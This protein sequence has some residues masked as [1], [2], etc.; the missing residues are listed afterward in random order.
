MNRIGRMAGR[1]AGVAVLAALWTTQAT[2]NTAGV[3]QFVAGD[4]RVALAGGSERPAAKGA[5]ISVGDTVTTARASMAQIK[6]GD[7]AIIVVQPE[8]RLTVAEFRY[9]GKEDG[10]EKVQFRLEQGGFRSVT[11]AIGHTNKGSYV[12]ETPIA[13]IGVRGTDHESYYFPTPSSIDGEP[14]QAG[15]YNK[16][17]VGLTYIRTGSGEVVIQP[18]QVGYAASAQDTPHLLGAMPE[19]FNRGF[20]PRSVQRGGRPG[21]E[22]SPVAA[23]QGGSSGNSAGRGTETLSGTSG[24]LA[25]YTAPQGSRGVNFG[26]TAVN[27][28]ISPNG[29]TLANAGGN[30]TWGVNWGT[31]QGGPTTVNGR[32]TS[33]STNFIASTNLTTAAQLAA[34][35][36]Q[37]VTANYNYVPG[38]GAVNG[39]ASPNGTINRL[40]V[41]VNLTTHTITNYSVNATVGAQ[42][43]SG[44][45]SGTFAQFTS[46]SGISIDGKCSGCVPGGGYPTAHGTA[47]GGF[48]GS[49]A[50]RMITSF[51]LKAATQSISGTG[52]LAR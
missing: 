38:S 47:N 15:I 48:V 16:V 18:N 9:S 6:M 21:A 45:G 37:L 35:P 44:S 39:T 52:F 25:G 20:S 50:E 8:S 13:H 11:G 29:A 7:G 51:G 27:P 4:V 19:F 14:A 31:W 43:W 41:G 33:G 3:F 36:Q 12:I 24:S 17:N 46:A 49:Q 40:S 1:L 32:V 5:P 42:N 30:S 10:T 22:I 28:S 34:L 23:N 26:E 2:A